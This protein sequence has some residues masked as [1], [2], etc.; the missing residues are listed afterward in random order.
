MSININAAITPLLHTTVSIP[1]DLLAVSQDTRVYLYSRC[2]TD[3]T[4]KKVTAE[5]NALRMMSYTKGWK[6]VGEFPDLCLDGSAGSNLVERDRMLASALTDPRPA[7]I[8]LVFSFSRLS[9]S[10]DEF[11]RISVQLMNN[12]WLIYSM[13]D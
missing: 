2:H 5:L 3:C 10:A 8:L 13:T 9:R 7:D 11:K 12:G 4:Q 6:V 1:S